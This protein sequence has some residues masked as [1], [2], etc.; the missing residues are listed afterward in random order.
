MITD[1]KPTTGVLEL[2]ASSAEIGRDDLYRLIS[3]FEHDGWP[4]FKALLDGVQVNECVASTFGKSAPVD[5]KWA[6]FY[7]GRFSLVNDIVAWPG[8]ANETSK[9]FKDQDELAKKT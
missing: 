4:V 1:S 7:S 8:S 6:D 3:M 5:E 9:I 2:G